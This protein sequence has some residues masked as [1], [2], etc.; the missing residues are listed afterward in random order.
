MARNNSNYDKSKPKYEWGIGWCS[1]NVTEKQVA[2]L[3][4]LAGQSDMKLQNLEQISRGGASGLIDELKRAASG[5]PHSR[6]YL[7]RD[8]SKYIIF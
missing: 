7:E 3:E 4:K 1:K 5:D 8:W 2:Y 6:R